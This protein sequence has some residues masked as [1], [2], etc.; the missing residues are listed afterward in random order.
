[1]KPASRRSV[2]GAAALA[3][4]QQ[5]LGDQLLDRLAQGRARHAQLGGQLALG[6]QAVAGLE[7]AIEDAPLEFV[8]DGV[9]ESLDCKLA[10]GHGTILNWSDQ[11]TTFARPQARPPKLEVYP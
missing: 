11:N 7:G 1:M 5:A 3:A 9:G 10:A 2:T 6:L 8:G 4:V